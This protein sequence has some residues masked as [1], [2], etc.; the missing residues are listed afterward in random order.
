METYCSFL[1]D[2]FSTFGSFRYRNTSTLCFCTIVRNDPTI[3]SSPYILLIFFSITHTISFSFLPSVI[4][5]TASLFF[6]SLSGFVLFYKNIVGTI[7]SWNDQIISFQH[8]I[9]HRTLL[10][11]KNGEDFSDPYW[12]S[13]VETLLNCMNGA[14]LSDMLC[15]VS[16]LF[17]DYDPAHDFLKISTKL[18]QRYYLNR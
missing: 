3:L 18:W 15:N 1:S 16:I 11:L 2:D 12:L 6:P 4:F 17:H 8:R 7:D 14:F 5:A 13:A 9:H 10:I